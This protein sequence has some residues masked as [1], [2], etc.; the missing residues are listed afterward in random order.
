MTDVDLG[1]AGIEGPFPVLNE[2][3]D[4]ERRSENGW[5]ARQLRQMGRSSRC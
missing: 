5:H 1:S 3:K 4:R 2:V